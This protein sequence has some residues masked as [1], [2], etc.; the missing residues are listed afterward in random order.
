MA[1]STISLQR[2][3][4]RASNRRGDAD[5][6]PLNKGKKYPAEPLDENEVRSLIRA[7]SRR[8]SATGR[9]SSCCGGHSCACRRCW[10]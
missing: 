3:N 1:K 6:E 4:P 2:R 5:F 9:S 8:A 10:P 7:C